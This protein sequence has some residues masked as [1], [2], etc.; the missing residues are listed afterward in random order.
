V[1]AN[2]L[3]RL[4]SLSPEPQGQ[5]PASAR[6]RRRRKPQPRGMLRAKAA[7]A[8]ADVGL[9]T[10]RAWDAAGLIPRPLRI[11]GCVLWALPELRA[12][13]D[14]GCPDRRTWEALRPGKLR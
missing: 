14:A 12:W 3:H 6:S 8:W 1:S 4:H 2:H 13:R 10:W 5:P 11:A 9:R 7:A